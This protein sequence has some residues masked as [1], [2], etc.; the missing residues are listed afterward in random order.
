MKSEIWVEPR[1]SGILVD[2]FY[3][4]GLLCAIVKMRPLDELEILNLQWRANIKT[5]VPEEY[6]NGYVELKEKNYD[7]QDLQDFVKSVELT[8]SGNLPFFNKNIIFIG[9][10]TNHVWNWKNPESRTAENVKK[11]VIRL[12]EEM[13]KMDWEIIQPLIM[14]RKL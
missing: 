7:Y 1:P 6:H 11:D 3:H 14:A 9:F 8:F 10:D 4:K 5:I 13:T 2:K 12:A